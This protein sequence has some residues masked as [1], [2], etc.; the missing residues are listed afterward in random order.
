MICYRVNGAI[1]GF[2]KDSTIVAI[3]DFAE[4]AVAVSMLSSVISL[5]SAAWMYCIYYPQD[6]DKFRVRPLPQHFPHLMP[7]GTLLKN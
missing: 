6:G 4:R 7:L 1:F 2:A 3:D 5:A